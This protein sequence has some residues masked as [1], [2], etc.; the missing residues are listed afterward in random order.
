MKLT[1]I[2]PHSGGVT[3]PLP[4]GGSM[5]VPHGE[6]VDVPDSLAARLLE[7]PANWQRVAPPKPKAPDKA[8]TTE[9]ESE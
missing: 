8:A 5:D 6:P 2:G 7:Q 9:K 3:V 1:Y 4:T